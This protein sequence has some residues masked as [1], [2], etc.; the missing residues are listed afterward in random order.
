METI[1]TPAQDTTA[2][3]S[4][5]TMKTVIKNTEPRKKLS[6]SKK[7]KGNTTMPTKTA[8][9]TSKTT[10][11]PKSAPKSVKAASAAGKQKTKAK[12]SAISS[13][14]RQEMIATTAYLIAEQRG[15]SGGNSVDDWFAAEQQVDTYLNTQERT[16]TAA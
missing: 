2:I 16:A 8:K 12:T 11:S 4:T 3:E 6:I 1:D 9:S 5:G 15:F 13:Q 14:Q 7:P 10:Q